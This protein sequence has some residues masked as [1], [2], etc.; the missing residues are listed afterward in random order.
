MDNDGLLQYGRLTKDFLF[1]LE[2]GVFLSSN[3]GDEY[4]NPIFAEKSM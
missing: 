4:G 2:E 1:A 3:C